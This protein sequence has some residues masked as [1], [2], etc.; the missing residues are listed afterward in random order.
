MLRSL[1]SYSSVTHTFKIRP[2]T[3]QIILGRE[4][5]NKCIAEARE[6][7]KCINLSDTFEKHLPG[8][9]T[10]TFVTGLVT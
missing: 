4:E 8:V 5:Q 7:D 1:T 6:H 3:Q 10:S 2:N 9:E